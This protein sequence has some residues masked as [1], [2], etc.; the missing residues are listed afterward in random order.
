MN[1]L[2]QGQGGVTLCILLLRPTNAPTI[3]LAIWLLNQSPNYA[4]DMDGTYNY[5]IRLQE[6]KHIHTHPQ[7]WVT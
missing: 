7:M 1:Q 6:M 3:P 5:E 4:S 2:L